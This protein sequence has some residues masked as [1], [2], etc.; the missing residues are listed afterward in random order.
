MALSKLSGDEQD[1]N[2]RVDTKLSPV[3]ILRH[4]PPVTI[5]YLLLS[6]PPTLNDIHQIYSRRAAPRWRSRR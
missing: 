4:R 3:H 6:G 5:Y 1:V 2:L